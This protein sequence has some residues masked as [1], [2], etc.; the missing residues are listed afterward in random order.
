MPNN[1][2]EKY[3][4]CFWDEDLFPEQSN[5]KFNLNRPRPKNIGDTFLDSFSAYFSPRPK[6]TKM[7]FWDEDVP[8]SQKYKN[9]FLGR[10]RALVPKIQMCILGRGRTL[11]PKIQICVLGRGRPF[12]DDD[13]NFGS[14]TNV[15]G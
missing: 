7:H 11:V 2:P 5:N 6:N 12:W 3:L 10:G 14:R 9:A 15:F 13:D 4:E 8:S 1:Y